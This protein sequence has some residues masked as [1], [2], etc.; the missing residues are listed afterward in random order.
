MGQTKRMLSAMAIMLAVQD[1]PCLAEKCAP[2]KPSAG[3]ADNDLGAKADAADA[4]GIAAGAKRLL[5]WSFPI[6]RTH[7]GVAL[8]NGNFGALVWGQGRLHITVNRAD[9]WDHRCGE[10]LMEGTT[11]ERLKAAYDPGDRS[12]MESAF[13]RKKW[14]MKSG[15]WTRPCRLPVGRFELVFADGLM[16]KRAELDC[17][18]GRLHVEV[19]TADGSRSGSLDLI[20]HLSRNLL[21]IEDRD[22]L[23]RDVVIRPS[24]DWVGEASDTSWPSLR[25][26]GLAPPERITGGSPWGWIQ[27]CPEDP[28]L[29][30]VCK[31]VSGGFAVCLAL[32]D[33]DKSA[34]STALEEIGRFEH[35]GAALLL[36][37]SERWWKEYW[38]ELP[39]LDLPSEFYSKFLTYAQWK[40]A[41]ATHPESSRPSGLQGPWVEEYQRAQWSADYH[42]NVNVQQIYS[43]GFPT[44]RF[45][46]FM[47]LFKMLESE[48]FQRIMRHNAKVLFGID[49]GLLLTHAVDDRGY[50]CGWISAGSTLDH[51]CGGW[52]AQLYWEYY[53]YTLDK[54]FLRRRA[55][56]FMLGVMRVYEEML[57]EHDGR[58]SIPVS[59]SAE[60]GATFDGGRAQNAGRDPSYQLAC[61]HM[62]VDALIEASEILGMPERPI[63]R[64]IKERLPAY[65]LIGKPG[66]EHIAIWEGQDLD[67]CHRHHSHLGCI[68]PFDTL[69]EMGEGARRVVD[70]SIDHWILKGM[71][72]WSEWCIPWAAIIQARLGFSEAPLVLLNMWREIFVNEGMATVYLPRFRGVTAHRRADMLKPK[73]T[74]E[75]MQL[76]GTMGGATALYEML[77]HTRGGTTYVFPAVSERWA[78][79]SFRNVRVPGAFRVSG[80]RR[81]GRTT[82][83]V[84]RSLKGGTIRLA[85]PGMDAA[86]LQKDGR[87]ERITLPA[88]VTLDSDGTAVLRRVN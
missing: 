19:G 72:Q 48:S 14:E 50:Q 11:Y 43:L 24:W 32:G 1:V 70:N 13:V 8:G 46:H 39:E 38:A 74:H 33:D 6:P 4:G 82:D 18:A 63:W 64:A 40:F 35:E 61:A 62:L 23:V 26:S 87:A 77:V 22:G 65:T 2:E 31:R 71:G 7:C 29:A 88:T 25:A 69:G 49:D 85:A 5:G 42:F 83:I 36:R 75:I 47:P 86:E 55:Y 21:F 30:S 73:E 68:Y 56:P 20:M 12:R 52:T 66:E 80:V 27:D 34:W 41:C 37:H 53:R 54:E 28:S 76:D 3:Q 84:I 17:G 15:A 45:E 78:D 57:E 44:G 58:L 9:F 60:Y 16:P 51:A 79:V 10:T 81:G 67:V 59:I